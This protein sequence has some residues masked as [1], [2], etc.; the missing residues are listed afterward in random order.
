MY[1]I[2]LFAGT[3]EGRTIAEQL[4]G[5]GRKVCVFT[6]TEYGES[7]IAAGEGVTV[8]SGRLTTE[9][10]EERM[11]ASP[12]AL[13]MD[14]THPY[15]AVVTEN[16]RTACTS[17]GLPYLRVLR[18]GSTE[19][20]KDAVYVDSPKAA[21]EYLAGTEGNVLLTTGSK[22]LHFFTEVPD[23]KERLYARVLSLPSVAAACA[24]LGFQGQHLICMQGPFS[25]EMNVA[26]IHMTNAKYLVTK[27]TGITGGYPEKVEAARACGVQLVI[28]GR[29]LQEE[30]VSVKE[31]LRIAGVTKDPREFSGEAAVSAETSPKQKSASV[32]CAGKEI[33]L[34]GIGMGGKGCPTLTVEARSFCD[35]ADLLVGA[36]RMVEAVA[37]PDQQVLK[38]YRYAAIAEAIEKTEAR[39]IAVLLS[40]D[41]GF[42]SGAKKLLEVLPEQVQVMPGIGSLVY[43]CSQLHLPWEDM[44]I[45]SNH[46]RISNMIGLC[47]TNKKVFSLLGKEEDVRTLCGKFLEYGMTDL[48]IHVG[49]RFGYPQEKILHGKPKDFLEYQGDPLSVIVVENP[50][51]RTIVTHGIPDEDFL[52]DKVPMTKEEIR[53]ISLSKLRLSADSVIYDVG[54]GSGSV[55]VEM[56]R[57]ALEGQVY[58]VEKN[59]TAVQL[60]RQNKKKFRTDNLVIIEGLA[61]EALKELPAPT[62]AFIGGSSGNMKEILELLLEKNP[63]IRVVI[64][65]ITL[66]SIGEALQ[67]MKELPFTDVD[68]AAVSTAKSKA[69]G[70]YHLMFGQN[71]VYV[72]S[73]SGCAAAPAEAVGFCTEIKGMND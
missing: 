38:E 1:D 33:A 28:I 70:R 3:T 71:P 43:F 57:M 34:I 67:C 39:T 52:R 54:A 66:E 45:T 11:K 48:T 37:S 56:A 25:A 58:A 40:G 20:L 63:R 64:N 53:E 68:I 15:A 8:Q 13:V 27:D 69:L 9:E 36:G 7:L 72:V 14:A 2:L 47:D 51:P 49:E 44:K 6:A 17:T 61:P 10:M 19:L 35:R 59:P 23:Y 29:P 24:D 22:E 65:T 31:A 21:A 5:S 18:E 41:V 73:A 4:K 30:G 62:H 26:L 46:G 32:R 42:F 60:L 50:S 12:D 55:S 16:I